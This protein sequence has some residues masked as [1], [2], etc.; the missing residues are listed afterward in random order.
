MATL[1]SSLVEY[2]G[3]LLHPS[4]DF[5]SE[6]HTTAIVCEHMLSFVTTEP[7]TMNLSEALKP[8]D[9]AQFL[10]AMHK[11]LKKTHAA[12]G[13]SSLFKTKLRT[14][15]TNGLVYETKNKSDR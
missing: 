7:D 12:I 3:S 8:P 14:F 6:L 2:Q 11:E 4:R 15:F 10:F 1:S 13:R 9:R 5:R